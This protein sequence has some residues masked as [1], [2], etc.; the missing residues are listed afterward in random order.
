MVLVIG[1]NESAPSNI[2][3]K[4]Y[5]AAVIL[6]GNIYMANIMG[7]MANYVSVISRRDNAFETK[8]DIANSI[9]QGID[10]SSS[11]QSEVRDYFY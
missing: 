10:I 9:M 8:L 4:F 5:S 3:L 2:T 1:G 11:T 6:I 7:S